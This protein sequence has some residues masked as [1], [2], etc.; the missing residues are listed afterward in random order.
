M[1]KSAI[2]LIFFVVMCS[3]NILLAGCGA[4]LPKSEA[5][6]ITSKA[7]SAGVSAKSGSASCNT[8]E[9]HQL[10]S[11]TSLAPMMT[12]F[13]SGSEVFPPTKSLIDSKIIAALQEEE[14]ST[15]VYS[16][17]GNVMTLTYS[18]GAK[19]VITIDNNGRMTEVKKLS[20][21]NTVL[22]KFTHNFGSFSAPLN[23]KNLM[24]TSPLLLA[25]ANYNSS[26]QL[27]S[28]T[29]NVN[30]Q[31]HTLGTPVSPYP[32][33]L[34]DVPPPMQGTTTDALQQQPPSPAVQACWNGCT[35]TYE[36]AKANAYSNLS[37]AVA[38]ALA[39]YVAGLFL[40]LAST[41]FY[42]LCAAG[43]F[44]AYSAAVA[45]A[46]AAW[47]ASLDQAAQDYENCL[48]QCC[49]SNGLPAGSWKPYVVTPVQ[50]VNDPWNEQAPPD[51]LN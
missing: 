45:L 21:S 20:V 48:D 5:S 28:I 32:P 26:Q 39:V 35:E 19:L 36:Q 37:I 13:Q 23:V 17:T 9:A 50:V 15:S 6:P 38:T 44:A 14:I 34:Y 7:K 47:I 31:T 49:T 3:L 10:A 40:C 42:P 4:N 8:C 27:Y 2:P 25:T 30:N 51:D 12:A 18:D 11:V 33:L 46:T 1:R 29:D 43:F 41:A 22:Q 24:G 16:R